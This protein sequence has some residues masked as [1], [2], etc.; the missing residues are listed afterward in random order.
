MLYIDAHMHMHAIWRDMRWV[1]LWIPSQRAWYARNEVT[2]GIV[3]PFVDSSKGFLCSHICLLCNIKHKPG[4]TVTTRVL[5][6]S[7]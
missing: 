6:A 7:P 2:H 5:P 1:L 4:P 3:L